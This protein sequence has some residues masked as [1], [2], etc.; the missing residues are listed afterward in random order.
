VWK[1][2]ELK[3]ARAARRGQ[4]A[5]GGGMVARFSPS[6]AFSFSFLVLSAVSET[7]RTRNE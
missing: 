3:N 1:A 5:G 2:E 6:F 4:V 7:P